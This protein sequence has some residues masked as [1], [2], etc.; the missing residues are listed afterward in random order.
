M[1]CACTLYGGQACI[2]IASVEAMIF[3]DLTLP[4]ML[5]LSCH[6]CLNPILILVAGTIILIT[7]YKYECRLMRP[8]ILECRILPVTHPC[9]RSMWS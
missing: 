1:D 2:R 8:I 5:R 3:E 4:P 6:E 7:F 9:R